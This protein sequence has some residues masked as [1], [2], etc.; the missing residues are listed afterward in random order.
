MSGRL[1]RPDRPLFGGNKMKLK[2]GPGWKAAYNETK[3]VYGGE[4]AFQGSWDCYEIS[5]EVFNSLT[6]NTDSSEAEKLI[7][8]GRHLYMHVNDRSGPPYSV[9]L[10]E[11]YPDYCPWMS[12]SD[13]GKTWSTELTDAVV[14][15]LESEKD[16]REQRRKKREE[17]SKN[18]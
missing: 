7:S 9:V 8:G 17:R 4:V 13:S 11:D 14:E 12:G 6:K 16:N 5:A 18:K 1:D 10:D 3:G 15:L 2:E